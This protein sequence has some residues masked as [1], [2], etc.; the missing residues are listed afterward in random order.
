ML[1]IIGDVHG[2]CTLLK[3]LLKSMGYQKSSAGYQHPE[4]K[5]V[6]VGDF[7]S[8]GPEIRQT[9]RLIRQMTEAGHAY[10]ILGNNE[11]NAI[12]HFLKNPEKGPLLKKGSKRSAF[13]GPILLEF[14]ND[15]PEWEDHRKWLR[16][17][18][19]FLDF[20]NVRIVHACWK[21]EHIEL[22]RTELPEGKIP[23]ATFRDLV[24][25]PA[26]PLSQAILQTTRGIHHI[27]PHDLALFDNHRRIHHFYRIKWWEDPV[28]KTFQQNSM[29]SK[30]LLPNYTIPPEISPT[31]GTYPEDAPPV[32][33]GH[34]CMGNG[35]FPLRNNL[36]CVDGCVMMSKKLVAYRWDGEQT[37]T[38]DKIL[39]VR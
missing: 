24:L 20:G 32:F 11:V 16:T 34:Y 4:R 5:A 39:F 35:P 37:L 26:S 7:V 21:N 36:C 30:F 23:K 2:H 28:G 19:F 22:L 33:F 6:F 25:T 3:N 12:L 17:L 38:E 8:R 1:D 15:P 14:R 13:I 29:E 31:G 18:P 10:T 9:I 27:L